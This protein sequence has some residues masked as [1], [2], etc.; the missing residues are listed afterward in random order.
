M[1]LQIILVQ[2]VRPR[3]RNSYK[4]LNPTLFAGDKFTVDEAIIREGTMQEELQV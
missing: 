3:K 4:P 1:R 2:E